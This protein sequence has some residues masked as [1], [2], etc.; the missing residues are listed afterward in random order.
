MYC[1]ERRLSVNETVSGTQPLEGVSRSHEI[2]AGTM[3]NCV[4]EE[5][6]PAVLE[7]VSFTLNT[8]SRM[9]VCSG[10]RPEPGSVPSPQSHE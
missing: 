5:V 7:T 2:S 3:N 9:Y 8:E 10:D 1:L 4:V 6:H